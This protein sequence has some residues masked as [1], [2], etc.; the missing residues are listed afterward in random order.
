MVPSGEFFMFIAVLLFHRRGYGVNSTV[1]IKGRSAHR[2]G[3][4]SGTA[5]VFRFPAGLFRKP[6][7]RPLYGVP[8]AGD[9]TVYMTA[10]VHERGRGQ[11]GTDRARRGA[12]GPG[13]GTGPGAGGRDRV[14]APGRRG[15]CRQDPA[16][17]GTVRAGGG[18][19]V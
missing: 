12:G 2:T 16:A 6:R 8:A 13:R 5:P 3:A 7:G 10:F 18:R 19:G 4:L 1:G 11:S 14:R 9:G 15:G 17:A